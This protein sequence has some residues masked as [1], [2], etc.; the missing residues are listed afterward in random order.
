MNTLSN[1]KSKIKL[2][3]VDNENIYLSAPSWDCDWYWGFGYL[4]NKNCH[5]Q[6]DGLTQIETYNFDKKVREYEFVNMYDGLKKH[7]GDSFIVTEDKDIWTLAELFCSFY[8]LNQYAEMCHTGGANMT[9]NPCKEILK[10]TEEETRINNIV[11]PQI[12]EEIYKVLA[13]YTKVN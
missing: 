10:N 11:L 1:Y 5:Y 6:I 13:K 12:F 3:I 2:G 4:G 7:F 8:T 9:T